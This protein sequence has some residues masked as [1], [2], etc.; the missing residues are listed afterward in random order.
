MFH[1]LADIENG[2]RQRAGL[3]RGNPGHL[4]VERG[5]QRADD[6]EHG[7]AEIG[8]VAVAVDE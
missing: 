5:E 4:G 7:D 2:R 1:S 6:A 8:E 3:L